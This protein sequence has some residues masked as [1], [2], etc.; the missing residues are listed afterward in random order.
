MHIFVERQASAQWSP[1]SLQEAQTKYPLLS[2]PLPFAN[3]EIADG[4]L[5]MAPDARD[6]TMSDVCLHIDALLGANSIKCKGCS[7]VTQTVLVRQLT[8]TAQTTVTPATVMAC[9]QCGFTRIRRSIRV[10]A[11]GTKLSLARTESLR[12]ATGKTSVSGNLEASAAAGSIQVSEKTAQR[13]ALFHSKQVLMLSEQVMAERIAQLRTLLDEYKLNVPIPEGGAK[14]P[15]ALQMTMTCPFYVALD[16]CYNARASNQAGWAAVSAFLVSTTTGVSTPLAVQIGTSVT[17]DPDYTFPQFRSDATAKGLEAVLVKRLIGRLRAGGINSLPLIVADQDAG[18]QKLLSSFAWAVGVDKNHYMLGATREILSLGTKMTTMK[19]F[20]TQRL[21]SELVGEVRQKLFEKKTGIDS[22]STA[23][24]VQTHQAPTDSTP[25]L[26]AATTESGC[27]GSSVLQL[28]AAADKSALEALNLQQTMSKPILLALN[29]MS[30]SGKCLHNDLFVSAA[31]KHEKFAKSRKRPAARR[32][33]PDTQYGTPSSIPPAIVVHYIKQRFV[34][35]V[36]QAAHQAK[37]DPSALRKLLQISVQHY[38]GDHE[39]CHLLFPGAAGAC[40][41]TLTPF[42]ED[43][44]YIECLTALYDEFFGTEGQIV[45]GSISLAVVLH[46]NACESFNSQLHRYVAK[47]TSYRSRWFE[48]P[49]KRFL[50][51]SCGDCAWR[52][53]LLQDSGLCLTEAQER[54]YAKMEANREYASS[55]VKS[56]ADAATKARGKSVKR[57]R[58][59]LAKH[60]EL[61]KGHSSRITN[62]EL[63]EDTLSQ[64]DPVSSVSQQQ[65]ADLAHCARSPGAVLQNRA[66]VGASGLGVAASGSRRRRSSSSAPATQS[67]SKV[68]RTDSTSEEEYGGSSTDDTSGGEYSEQSDSE[69]ETLQPTAGAD[70]TFTQG[71][72]QGWVKG[73]VRFMDNINGKQYFLRE[74]F[75]NNSWQQFYFDAVTGEIDRHEGLVQCTRATWPLPSDEEDT[76]KPDG[77]KVH[78]SEA[79]GFCAAQHVLECDLLREIDRH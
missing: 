1:A 36:Y 61:Y 58:A 32:T 43:S 27:S 37:G 6:F 68:A 63:R 18:V 35:N 29:H 39:Q 70:L 16:G 49:L 44:V 51:L 46:T 64:F 40:K 72:A 52:E 9:A 28:R 5:K 47:R 57:D 62:P 15:A 54:L 17:A 71:V 10:G 48:G 74:A 2:H 3:A 11:T 78:S 69:Q 41:S 77:T 26:A 42:S 66:A 56:G 4:F 55:R 45:R 53:M 50:D 33:A 30:A 59:Q 67:K 24:E 25:S 73:S 38:L 31:E 76:S 21:R 20:G 23:E 79:R 12:L 75:L 65:E 22:S 8:P 13:A 7:K 34:R 14:G 60:P 19:A